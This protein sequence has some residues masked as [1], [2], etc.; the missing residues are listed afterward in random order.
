LMVFAVTLYCMDFD[1]YFRAREKISFSL[2]G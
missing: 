2:Q 1:I